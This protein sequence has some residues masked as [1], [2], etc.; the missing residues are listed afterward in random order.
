MAKVRIQPHLVASTRAVTWAGWHLETKDGRR[1]LGSQ[2]DAWDYD[3]ALTIGTSPEIDTFE[4]IKS[5]GIE[6]PSQIHVVVTVDCSSTS[7][8]FLAHAPV[9]QYL[10]GSDRWIGVDIPRGAAALDLKMTCQLVLMAD[11]RS[12]GNAARFKGSRLT[13]SPTTRLV[14]EGEASRFPTEALSFSDL[15]WEPAAWSVRIDLEDLDEAFRGAVRLVLNTDHPVGAALSSM[16]PRTYGALGSVL[17]IDIVRSV[18]LTAIEHISRGGKAQSGFEE[19]SFG[20][21]AEQMSNDHFGMGLSDIAE[22]RA[23]N[24]ARFER[25][26]QSSIGMELTLS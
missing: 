9:D 12:S 16:D 20:S 13:T 11:R 5:T 17:R 23:T 8:R 10:G 1:E 21:V 24:P 14:L 4:L 3:Q 19:E 2:L 22:L 18:L 25:V 26:L 7:R 6:D 15:R